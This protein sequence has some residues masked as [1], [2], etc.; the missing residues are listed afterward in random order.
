MDN[1]HL[2]VNDGLGEAALA[3]VTNTRS[4]GAT[5]IEVDTVA[6][7]P[8]D[9]VATYGELLPSGFIDPATAVL[10]YGHLSGSDIE[11]DGF[12]PGSVDAGNDTSDVVVIRPNGFVQNFMGE[13]IETISQ[14]DG[15]GLADDVVDTD[16]IVDEA[17]TESKIADDAILLGHASVTSAQNGFSSGAD[18]TGLSVTVTA[19]TSRGIKITAYAPFVASSTG[20][21]ILLIKEGSTT[22]NS[23]STHISTASRQAGA[24]AIAFIAAPTAG[25]HTYKL[26]SD[27][28]AG[29]VNMNASATNPAFILVEAV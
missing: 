16:Q 5:T 24:I 11:I 29:T 19:P 22:L 14:A 25:S 27:H 10:F 2:K 21:V 6:N 23:Y 18:L 17:V 20:N 8:T 12:M 28:S 9:F 15:S 26:T 7:W 3:H 13:F 4:I 1:T